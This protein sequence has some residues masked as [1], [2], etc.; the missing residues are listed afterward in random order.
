M[1][2]DLIFARDRRIS[3]KGPGTPGELHDRY[4]WDGSRVNVSGS[5]NCEGQLYRM[6]LPSMISAC[7]SITSRPSW[8]FSRRQAFK[9]FPP[10]CFRTINRKSLLGEFT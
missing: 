9:L 4:S 1:P 2:Q 8:S 3:T 10:D 6:A 5:D 7:L